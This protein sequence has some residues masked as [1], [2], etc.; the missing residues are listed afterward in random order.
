MISLFF[1]KL[2]FR[3]FKLKIRLKAYYFRLLPKSKTPN[4]GL[5]AGLVGCGNFA[6]YAYI[7]AFNR[8][9]MPV[10]ITGLYSNNSRSSE[11]TQRFLRYKTKVF[12]SYEELLNS[13]IKAVILTLPNH[14][15]YQYIIKALESGMD[16]FCEKPV[17]HN[18][19][20]AL[21][22][23]S[24]L[25]N[26]K[27]ILM[28]GF[29]QRYL[30][31]IKIIK[32]LIENNKIG[33]ICEVRA[34]HNQNIANHL[35]KTNWLNDSK[36]SGGGVLYNAGIHLVNLMLYFFGPVDSVFAKLEYR[37]IPE[38]FGEDTADCD[39]YFKSGVKG[40]ITASYINQ[41]Q[42]SYEHLI[43]K[44]SKGEIYTDLKTSSIMYRP[45]HLLKWRNIYCKKELVV[46]SV[47]NELLHFY[48]CIEKRIKPDTD[49]V[50]SINTLRVI[51]A[52]YL[53][54]SEKRRI[55]VK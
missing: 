37:E 11:R 25:E 54:S 2:Y 33:E 3:F 15:H 31:R 23:S 4:K 47:F 34:F 55:F 16:V 52:V 43:I 17:T 50:D 30:A 14:L 32:L 27:N 26:R 39:F 9:K 1:W 42:S 40:M 41:V 12:L 19:S 46:D 44:G 6:R 53:S 38:A 18:L 8:R 21:R 7:P 36:K 45:N 28:V 29:N 20:D 5:P 51:E 10:V 22:I 49:I 48:N 24:Y 13:G 35:K